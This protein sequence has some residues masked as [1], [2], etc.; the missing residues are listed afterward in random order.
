MAV[1]SA[2]GANTTSSST[3]SPAFPN[4]LSTGS[5]GR[6]WVAIPSPRNPVL[7]W[8]HPRRP[9]LRR[10]IWAMPERLQ[11]PPQRTTWVMAVDADGRV[12]DDLQA[13]HGYDLVTGVREHDGTLYL[14]S[15]TDTAVAAVPLSTG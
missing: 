3:T 8:A 10:A 14:G 1:R 6:L 11:P 5:G 12:V 4:N 9:W 13:R 2:A 7:D 15:L